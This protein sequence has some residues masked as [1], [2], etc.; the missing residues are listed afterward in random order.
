MQ[1]LLDEMFPLGKV[2]LIAEPG[3]Y[4][5][6]SSHTLV[7]NVIGLRKFE[8]TEDKKE[9]DP[10]SS[11]SSSL[12]PRKQY[13]FSYY[14][15]DGLYGAFNNI[16]FD[17]AHVKPV[18]L[19]PTSECPP[20][21]DQPHYPSTIFGPTCDGIDCIIKD[22]PLPQ[23]N[24]GDWIYFPNMGACEFPFFHSHF[25]S[26]SLSFHCTLSHSSLITLPFLD[27]KAAASQFNGFQLAR[28]YYFL[29]SREFLE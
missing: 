26:V 11:S 2:R 15:N 13:K 23:L 8:I 14:V 28:S 7:V 9:S 29:S 5:V 19:P 16:M 17:H 1:P 4:F 12:P 27:T 21:S 20:F 22:Y 25:L 10:L 3:R 18:P 6:A 24:V